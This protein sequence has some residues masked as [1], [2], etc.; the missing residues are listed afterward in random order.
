M[1]DDKTPKKADLVLEGGGV[2]GLAL[3]GALKVLEEAGYTFPRVGGTSAGAIVGSLIAAGVSA[4][5]LRTIM[6]ETNFS[7]FMDK[8]T[9]QRYTGHLGTGYGL[10]FEQGMYQGDFFLGY[11]RNLLQEAGVDTFDQLEVESDDHASLPVDAR[12]RLVVMASDI[13]R[14]ELVRLPWDLQEKYQVDPDDFS[15]ASAVRASMAIPFFFRPFYMRRGGQRGRGARHTL[16]DGGMLS[17][18]PID[19]FDRKDG[20]APRW[21]TFG[22]K[23]SAKVEDKTPEGSQDVDGSIDQVKAMIKTMTSFH[24]SLHVGTKAV[25][26]RTIFIDNLG[27][28]SVDFDLDRDTQDALYESGQHAARDFIDDWNFEK[29]K[30]DRRPDQ[31]ESDPENGETAGV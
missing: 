27:V 17:N 23:L 8:G 14:N 28:S 20:K 6:L 26:D 4:D 9:V 13:R 30:D 12:H 31:N 3:V 25:I 10:W 16:V 18:F 11:I 15:V 21:P 24:D 5:D 22:M 7:D 2:K 1:A 19:V 29:Y